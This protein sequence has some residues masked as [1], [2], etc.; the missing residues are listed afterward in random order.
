[1]TIS[2]DLDVAI[3]RATAISQ[4]LTVLSEVG[5]PLLDTQTTVQ[6]NRAAHD[7][8]EATLTG[9]AE[10][11][12]AV[13]TATSNLQSVARE[14]EAMDSSLGESLRGSIGNFK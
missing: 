5:N 8:I 10:I 14:F 6:G 12:A 2:S 7:A 11:S 13:K 9:G 3:Q 1:M 4:A